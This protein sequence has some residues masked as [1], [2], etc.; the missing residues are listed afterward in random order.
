MIKEKQTD[1][2][3]DKL[4]MNVLVTL[5]A[6]PCLALVGFVL[7]MIFGLSE[8]LAGLRASKTGVNTWPISTPW[9]LAGIFGIPLLLLGLLLFRKKK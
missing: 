4:L 3:N 7:Y 2:G 6:L 8:L 9:I 1:P 5:V